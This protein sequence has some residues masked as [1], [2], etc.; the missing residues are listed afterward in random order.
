MHAPARAWITHL[1]VPGYTKPH[2]HRVII[3]ERAHEPRDKSGSPL[4]PDGAGATPCHLGP[5]H[6]Y[7]LQEATCFKWSTYVGNLSLSWIKTNNYGVPGWEKAF[8]ANNGADI[9]AIRRQKGLYLSNPLIMIS[10]PSAV[11][12]VRGQVYCDFQATWG[13]PLFQNLSLC[14]TCKDMS[15]AYSPPLS[16]PAP[17]TSSWVP[18]CPSCAPWPSC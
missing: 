14:I 8:G 18:C 2:K 15:Q 5:L 13:L 7:C 6:G 12:R 10:Q 16:Q 3:A 17:P 9:K 1:Q 11:S 4:V